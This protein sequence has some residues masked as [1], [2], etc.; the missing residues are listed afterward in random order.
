[1]AVNPS[2]RAVLAASAAAV[3]LLLTACKGVQVLGAPRPAPGDVAALRSAIGTEEHLIASYRQA[4]TGITGASTAALAGLG[5]VLAEHE[6]HLAQLRS[7][8][9]EPAGSGSPALGSPAPGSPAGAAGV[10]AGL[11]PAAGFLEAA[12]RAASDRLISDV[13]AVPGSLAQLFASI[14]ASE[15][16]HVPYLKSIGQAR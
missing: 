1:V 12:E 3:P 14:A 2:R 10:P 8:L 7:R 11:A 9:V 6:Q 13:E 15:A 16:T 4:M 5:V